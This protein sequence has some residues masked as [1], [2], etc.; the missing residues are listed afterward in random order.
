MCFFL[1][2]KIYELKKG[3]PECRMLPWY[4]LM[5]MA[6]ASSS[7]AQSISAALNAIRSMLLSFPCPTCGYGQE[8]LSLA[9][10]KV[11]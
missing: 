8:W 1:R 3:A 10:L 9:R 5:W 2:L 6:Y 4:G 7:A 11:S